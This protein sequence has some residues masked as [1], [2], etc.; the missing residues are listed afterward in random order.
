MVWNLRTFD[1]TLRDGDAFNYLFSI[2]TLALGAA[3]ALWHPESA[4]NRS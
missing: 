2:A 1:G 4:R 3:T